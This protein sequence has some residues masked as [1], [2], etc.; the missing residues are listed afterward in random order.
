MAR[1]GPGST[2]PLPPFLRVEGGIAREVDQ[3]QE[4]ARRGRHSPPRWCC[5]HVAATRKA[6]AVTSR[7][8]ATKSRP[9]APSPCTSASPQNPLIPGNTTESEGNQVVNSL[10]TGLVTVRRREPARVQRGRGVHGVRG[11]H[12]VDDHAEGRLDVPR[13]DAGELGVFRQR[14][15]LHRRERERAGGFRLLF[16]GI[17]GWE[18]VQAPTNEAQGEITPHLRPQPR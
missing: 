5:P 3:A 10:W 17:A 15:E 9:V 2:R 13:R 16:P 12:H 6:A 8:V 4:C 1:S 7:A 11:Q 18:D 14:V